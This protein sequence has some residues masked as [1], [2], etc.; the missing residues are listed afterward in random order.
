MQV[1]TT[2]S[3]VV[4]PYLY[5]SSRTPTPAYPT[6]PRGLRALISH[7]HLLLMVRPKRK[8]QSTQDGC[9][10]CNSAK[11]IDSSW[12]CC[13]VCRQWFH[14]PCVALTEDQVGHITSYHCDDCSADHGPSHMKRKLKRSVVKID[15]VAL[16]QG[17]TFALDKSMHPHVPPFK[18]FAPEVNLNAKQTYVDV[19]APADLVKEYVLAGLTRPVLVPNV[20]TGDCGMQLPCPR[21]DLLVR[22]IAEKTGGDAKVE[23]MDVLSQQSESPA[24][25][26]LQWEK[27][28]YTLLADRDRIR[29][30]ISLEVSDVPDLGASFVRPQMVRDLDIVDKV[31]RGDDPRPKVTVYCLMS[32][33]RS[34]TDFH[35]DFLG[36]PVYY[37]VCLGS[38]T[39]LMYPP[40]AKNLELYQLWCDE[41]QQNFIWFA[42]YTRKLGRKKRQPE[43]GFKV[44]LKKGD[45]FIIP[46]GW[47]H[48]VYTPEDAVIVG[49]NYL[50]LRDIP[51]HLTIY[52]LERDTH[53]PAKYRFPKF[54]RVMWLASWYYYN[55][56]VE[57][58]QDAVNNA[59]SSEDIN[60]C[61]TILRALITHLTRHYEI[62]ITN[63]TARKSIP[64]DLIGKDIEGYLARLEL[65]EN[66]FA[67]TDKHIKTEA[68]PLL[69]LATVESATVAPDQ[70]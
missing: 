21:S 62:S 41:P 3:P 8:L 13:D 51:M 65:W 19:L 35:I 12:I 34:Y 18:E 63:A 48:A 36:T 37:T 1:N 44:N 22:Y 39:F 11:D 28:F 14:T 46:S 20:D 45:L 29:N 2:H 16:D 17:D 70:L 58:L 25:S 68:D 33:A 53:V 50:T 43:N 69:S 67:Q 27:Y 66:S 56:Q 57:F 49:G 15:Y 30:V 55:H 61:R 26:L 52:S 60:T 32:V 10:K 24:W 31:W 4:H 9:G 6:I 38:K 7:H 42:E 59:D 23:V 40:T 54:F 64:I 5:S 47:I